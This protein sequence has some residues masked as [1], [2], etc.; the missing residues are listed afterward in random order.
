MLIA[1]VLDND[2]PLPVDQVSAPEEPAARIAKLDIDLGLRQ[3]RLSDREPQQGFRA[4]FRTRADQVHRAGRGSLSSA[5]EELDSFLEP[6]QRNPRS[7]VIPLILIDGPKNKGISGRHQV[8]QAELGRELAEEGLRIHQG[9]SMPPHD[10]DQRIL[11]QVPSH[12]DSPRRSPGCGHADVNR[13]CC[14]GLRQRKRPQPGRCH[15]AEEGTFRDCNKQSSAPVEQFLVGGPGLPASALD[16]DAAEWLCQ[17]TTPQPGLAEADRAPLGNR[18]RLALESGR[19]GLA[20]VRHAT[21]WPKRP[22]TTP[23]YPQPSNRV[24][25][26]VSLS[27]REAPGSGHW[28]SRTSSTAGP[29]AATPPERV[30][31]PHRRW[32]SDESPA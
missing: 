7:F 4:G 9:Q 21:C 18:E 22:Q 30:P 23:T 5:A 6:R 12:R 19:E 15:M 8:G 24:A 26:S 3:P 17:V 28:I 2:S 13:C 20:R 25:S 10:T 16:P 32:R 29:A 1:V 14:R 11:D 27:G 31:R